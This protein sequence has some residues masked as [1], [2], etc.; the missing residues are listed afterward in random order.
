MVSV[1]LQTIVQSESY[2]DDL[3]AHTGDTLREKY[4]KN[5]DQISFN[6]RIVCICVCVSSCVYM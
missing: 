2:S 6:V 1:D 4:A 3:S 5:C